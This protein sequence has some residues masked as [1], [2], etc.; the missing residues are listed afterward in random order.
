MTAMKMP[1]IK[2]PAME[3]WPL[4]PAE[5]RRP[6]WGETRGQVQRWARPFPTMPAA[7]AVPRPPVHALP[8][9][10]R[11]C[12]RSATAR[13]IWSCRPNALCLLA[14]RRVLL[15][16]QSTPNVQPGQH[17]A[18]AWLPACPQP[19]LQTAT[20][21]KQPARGSLPASVLYARRRLASVTDRHLLFVY[22]SSLNGFSVVHFQVGFVSLTVTA[23][24]IAA[25]VMAS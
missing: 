2:T 16:T 23:F 11:R 5:R 25:G 17:L 7:Q 24:F 8:R 3:A 14:I 20:T 21:C 18:A 6:L 19:P 22:F 15:D 13:P 10:S 1:A 4:P 9:S 12:Y